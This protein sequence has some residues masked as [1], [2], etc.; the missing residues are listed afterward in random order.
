MEGK[1]KPTNREEWRARVER[2]KASGR[3]AEEFSRELGIN[4]GTLKYWQ[5]R[6]SKDERSA[7]KSRKSRALP[8]V[9]VRPAIVESAVG[10]EVELPTG[11]RLRVPDRFNSVALERLLQVLER[12]R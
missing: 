5:Y 2:W 8:F 7:S 10:F 4:A 6:F 11:V 3:S 1:A 12:R 9:E